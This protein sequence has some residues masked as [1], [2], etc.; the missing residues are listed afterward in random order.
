MNELATL[1]EMAGIYARLDKHEQLK[2]FILEFIDVIPKD[3]AGFD[4]LCYC[5]YRA[6]DYR[7]AIKYGELA[8]AASTGDTAT[9]IRFNLGKCYLNAN[10]PFKSRNCFDIVCKTKP[11]QL[12]CKLDLSAA[13]FACNQKEEAKQLLLS[14]AAHSEQLEPREQMAIKFNLSSHMMREGNFK[15]GMEYLTFGRRLRVFGADTHNYPIPEWDGT[16]KTNQHILIVGEGGI[17]DEIINVRFAEHISKL[18]MRVSFASC[19]GMSSV[20]SRLPFEKVQ[21]YRRFSTDIADIA[22]YDVWTPAMSLPALLKLDAGE[23]WTGPYL[24]VDFDINKKWEKRMLG[25]KKI[26]IRWS[27]NP[28]YE[29]DLHRSISLDRVDSCIPSD[30]IKYSLQKEGSEIL[31]NYTHITDLNPELETFEDALAA[32][33]NLDVVVT[34]CTSIAHAAC[35]LGKRVFVMVPIMDYYV[36]AEGKSKSSWYGDNVTIIRQTVPKNWDSSYE[37]LRAALAA[38]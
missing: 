7:N 29:Q 20:Y 38:L 25:S 9:A 30:W 15:L 28:L 18:G 36:W 34:S 12:D 35:A 32:I 24:S 27:G 10:E 11:E 17:G 13:L 19:H 14:L 8:L 16:I 2:Q 26:G 33:N 21:D 5:Y 23:L 37:E 3:P 6:K 22:S 4:L 1:H 31:K